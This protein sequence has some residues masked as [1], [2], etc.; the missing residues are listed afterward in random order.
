MAFGK[1]NVVKLD[2]FNYNIA[3]LGEGG[4][5]KTTLVKEMCEKYLPEGGYLFAECGKEEGADSISDINYINC[6]DLHSDY[7]EFTNSVGF[8]ILI[9]DILENKSKSYPTLKVLIVDTYDE[10]RKII[11]PEVIRMHNKAHPDKRVVSIK[12]CFG[13]YMAGDDKVDDLLLEKLWSL[14]KVGVHFFLIGHTRLHERTDNDTGE[15]YVQLASNVS[16]RS[17][18]TIKTKL[19]FLGLAHIDRTIVKENKGNKS[20]GRITSEVRKITFRDDNYSLDSKSRFADVIEEC[21]FTPDAFYNAMVDAI[22]AEAEKG[23][24]GLKA[25]EKETENFEKE[26]KSCAEKFSESVKNNSIDE[27]K[28]EELI[29]VI[30]AKFTSADDDTKAKVK[31]LMAQYDISN[32]KSTEVSTK[33]LEE[34]VKLLQ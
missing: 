25:S 27:D 10:L 6:P 4:V 33:G 5:G 22:K 14:K 24:G 9:D 16:D 17:F 21:E 2:P 13:G 1:K 32:F 18:N 30:K 11:V 3:L 19:H 26:E 23:K 20:Q 28:N 7:D 15:S 29:D 12:S 31:E 8:D 34:I